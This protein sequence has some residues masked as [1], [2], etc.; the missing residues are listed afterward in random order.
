MA[1]HAQ[2]DL[3]ADRRAW[4]Y[5]T[6]AFLGRDLTGATLKL[7]VRATKD[8]TGTPLVALT[9]AADGD[10]GVTLLYAGTD[11]VSAHVAASRV[12]S[13]IYKQT[14]PA[15][16]LVY[17]PTDS[18]VLSRIR[19]TIEA[20][21]LA[22]FPFP[23]ERGD[24]WSGFHDLIGYDGTVVVLQTVLMSGAFILRAGATIP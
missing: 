16:G 15:T 17:A 13:D 2:I 3:I 12:G 6:F 8:T 24:D 21:T 14:N 19:V 4:L 20:A 23:E 9:P 22:A 1:R 18:L 11:T 7:Q 10:Q 5:E